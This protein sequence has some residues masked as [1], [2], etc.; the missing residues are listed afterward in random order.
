[1]HESIDERDD[2]AGIGEDFGP[3]AERLIGG[4]ND[5]VFLIAARDDLEEQVGIARVIG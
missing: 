1:M 5:R 2:T 4:D 3:F